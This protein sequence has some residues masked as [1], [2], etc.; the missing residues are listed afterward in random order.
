MRN[1]GGS[2][3]IAAVTT[4]L[5]RGAQSHQ[6]TMVSHLTPYDPVFQQRVS[7][8][9][10]SMTAQQAYAAIYQTLVRQATLLAYIDNFRLLAFLC[11]ICT[12]AAYCSRKSVPGESLLQCIEG[13][14]MDADCLRIRIPRHP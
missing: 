7:Q 13:T 4:M 14:R 1:V 9:V 6:A 2:F 8:M 11:L 3:G 10:T 12:P 5:A